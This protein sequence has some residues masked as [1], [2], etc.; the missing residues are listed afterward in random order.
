MVTCSG[1]GSR[2][3]VVPLLPFEL[4]VVPSPLPLADII[5]LVVEVAEEKKADCTAPAGA[6]AISL[7]SLALRTFRSLDPRDWRRSVVGPLKWRN[8]YNGK[9]K[10][11]SAFV[12]CHGQV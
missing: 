12:A 10:E 8:N 5:E 6:S 3:G 9:E 7:T 4:V 2:L 1:S 11:V